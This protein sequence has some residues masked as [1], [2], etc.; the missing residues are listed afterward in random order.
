MKIIKNEKLIQ[1]NGKIG[2]WLSIGALAV[3]GGG[4]YISFTKPEWFVYSLVCLVLGFILTQI[5]MYMS[6]RWGRS[7]R[8]DEKI[9]TSLKG[10]HSEFNLYHYSSPV[11]HLLIGPAGIWVLLPYQQ[12]GAAY[13]EKKRWKVKG[14]GFMQAYMRI[15][16]QEGIGRPDIEAETETALVKKFLAKHLEENAIPEVKAVMVF[17]HDQV[18]VEAGESPVA[19]MKLKR[20]KEFLREES[21][22]RKLT[23]MQIQ[24]INQ[25]L[26]A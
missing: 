12:A 14:G 5:G 3:L 20:L 11:S 15:F 13:F 19:A 26:E 8:P 23:S 9:D 22:T 25:A 16:G 17:T 1:R 18:E 10:L 7:P 24:Q 4:M 6:T 21:K 2:G